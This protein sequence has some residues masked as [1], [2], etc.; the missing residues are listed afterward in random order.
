MIRSVAQLSELD[1]VVAGERLALPLPEKARETL[2]ACGLDLVPDLFRGAVN[3]VETQY[4]V[5]DAEGC[6]GPATR[7]YFA[8]ADKG[9][10]LAWAERNGRCRVIKMAGAIKGDRVYVSTIPNVY[11]EVQS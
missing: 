2:R 6:S 7:V 10:A 3:V 5:V 8:T 9:E 4:A 11:G 1:A